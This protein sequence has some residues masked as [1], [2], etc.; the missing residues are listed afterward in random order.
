M[1]HQ[2]VADQVGMARRSIIQIELGR[3]KNPHYVTI[4]KLAPFYGMEH[5]ELRAILE[6]ADDDS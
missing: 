4:R 5:A 1:S 6:Q 2:D 3:V